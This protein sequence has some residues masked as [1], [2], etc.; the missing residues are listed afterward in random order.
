MPLWDLRDT[1]MNDSSNPKK[2]HVRRWL[3]VVSFFAALAALWWAGHP[4]KTTV[5]IHRGESIHHV[6]QRLEE[7]HV[8]SSA[9]LFTWIVRLSGG[10]HALHAGEF[11][12]PHGNM[13]R[14]LWALYLGKPLL[15]SVTI[16]E[17]YNLY[18]IDDLLAKQGLIQA[19]EFSAIASSSQLLAPYGLEKAPS[20]E[21][22]LFPETYAFSKVDSARMMAHLMV[23]K[24]F[25][26]YHAFRDR[27]VLGGMP[28]AVAS[29]PLLHIVTLASVIE[30]ETGQKE[31]RPLVASV[32]F[33]RLRL[34]M[35]L[36]SDPTTIYGLLPH[37]EG[38]LHKR[39]LESMTPYNTYRVPALPVGPI[40]NPG[41]ASLEAVFTPAASDYLY[42]V[43]DNQGHHFFSRSYHEHANLV[44]QYQKKNRAPGNQ[45]HTLKSRHLTH[46]QHRIT[47]EKH[48]APRHQASHPKT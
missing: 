31:E 22:F 10:R 47:K 9:S 26:R 41:L 23:Q 4:E 27:M 45:P 39:D 34:H 24:F 2:G 44:D 15:H 12:V 37:Y 13:L 5:F 1:P 28:N 8:I 33:N 48:Y 25:E 20:L 36:Q 35:R 17:G 42:F 43:A 30:K 11:E 7:E 14:V 16:P 32:F 21:G 6:A 40:C 29:W 18:Q 3:L 46:P 38:R 19:G